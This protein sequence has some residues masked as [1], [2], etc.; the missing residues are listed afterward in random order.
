MRKV[1]LEF[2]I[3][4][5]LELRE[6]SGAALSKPWEWCALKQ[7]FTTFIVSWHAEK[8]I[9]FVKHTRMNGGSSLTSRGKHPRSFNS[10]ASGLS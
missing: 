2:G 4:G 9:V 1:R 3:E 8:S 7:S 6:E 5:Y 10:T